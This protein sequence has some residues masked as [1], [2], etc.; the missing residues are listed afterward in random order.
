MSWTFEVHDELGS[1]SDVCKT[2][3]EQNS[4]HKIAVQA[5][6]QTNGRGTRGRQWADPGGNLAISFLYRPHDFLS[7][8]TAVPF[9]TAVAVHDALF[10]LCGDALKKEAL[11]LKWP[12][13]LLL[14]QRKVAGILIETGGASD[15]QNTGWVVIG[16]GVNM[17]SAPDIPGRALAALAELGQQWDPQ[18]LGRIIGACLDARFAQWEQAGFESIRQDWLKRAH[19]IGHRLAVRRG[20]N[21]IEGE[22][23]GLD[24]MGRLLLTRSNGETIPVVTGE[25]L[26]G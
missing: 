1:T 17:Y 10:A 3:A 13:D 7:F 24:L 9:L 20:E 22:F 26:L 15:S 18:E 11:T 2:Y 25:I 23:S 12:N 19:P 16:I 6:R 14:F 5:L 21:Y 8:L 4:Y